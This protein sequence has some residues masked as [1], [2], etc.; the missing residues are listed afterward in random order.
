MRLFCHPFFVVLTERCHDHDQKLRGLCSFRDQIGGLSD[1]CESQSFPWLD[2]V[3]F[4][5]VNGQ[6]YEYYA[7][8]HA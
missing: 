3:S 1:Y 6:S 7:N 2:S 4:F 8:S 5:E